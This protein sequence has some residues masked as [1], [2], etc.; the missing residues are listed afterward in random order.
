MICW[1]I[2]KM[3][4]FKKCFICNKRKNIQRIAWSEYKMDF[5]YFYHVDCLKNIINTP[6]NNKEINEIVVN[7]L[8]FMKITLEK[9]NITLK[10]LQLLKEENFLEKIN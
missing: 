1:I 5:E 8:D 9:K 10:K 2:K 7:I 4:V 6:S 3:N